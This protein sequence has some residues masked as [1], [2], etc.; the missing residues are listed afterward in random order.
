MIFE[1]RSS[2]GGGILKKLQSSAG[3]V[4]IIPRFYGMA[5]DYRIRPINIASGYF[6]NFKFIHAMLF[7]KSIR[8][9]LV[10][11]NAVRA[12][13]SV[14]I[15]CK[16]YQLENWKPTRAD[17]TLPVIYSEFSLNARAPY[18]VAKKSLL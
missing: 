14:Q 17:A 13:V 12:I 5:N 16:K 3:C 7:S 9:Y 1:A 18:I 2:Y 11:Y 10:I 8:V 4:C 6:I 15:N